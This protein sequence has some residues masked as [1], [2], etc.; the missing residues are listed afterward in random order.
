MRWRLIAT[1]S[2]PDRVEGRDSKDR[3]ATVLRTTVT[4]VALVNNPPII[5]G[6]SATT[7]LMIG[8]PI[9]GAFTI[10]DSDGDMLKNVRVHVSRSFKGSECVSDIGNYDS[11]QLGGSKSFSG[12]ASMSASAAILYLKV[13][14][15][16]ARTSRHWFNTAP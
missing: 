9:G 4:V 13:E 8:A 11:L 10:T 5:S 16:T 2:H 6:F 7:P 12:C 1:G 15:A 14:G 3:Q